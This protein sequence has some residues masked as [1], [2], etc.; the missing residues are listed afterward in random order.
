MIA[1]LLLFVGIIGG[2][3]S[4]G[5]F[6]LIFVPL[7]LVMLAVAAGAGILGRSSQD[8]SEGDRQPSNTEP[9]P[10]RHTPPQGTAAPATP[11]DL[12]DAR[13]SQQ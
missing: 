5:I 9:A 12:A 6:T 13:R 7:G 11:E 1:G 3:A 2:V 10:L 4:G 8:K